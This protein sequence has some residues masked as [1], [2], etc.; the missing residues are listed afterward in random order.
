[1]SIQSRSF[2]ILQV[3]DTPSDAA[4]TARALKAS[5]IPHWIQIVTDGEQA[6]AFL[7]RRAKFAD[8]PRPDLVLLDLG[9]PGLTGHDVLNVIK[10]DDDLRS[11]PVVVF[12]TL[13][14]EES[15]IL[16]YERF[17]NSYVVKPSDLSS[18]IA[19]IQAIVSYWF[20]T[21]RLTA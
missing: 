7:T 21:N 1:M 5:G 14:T 20:D 15:Q 19:K 17:A 12:T 16:A 3:E 2:T 8:A 9:L 10:H 13:D 18:F 6:L 4:L 11:I